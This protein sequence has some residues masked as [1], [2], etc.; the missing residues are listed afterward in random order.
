M[1][2]QL[3]NY[4]TYLINTQKSLTYYNNLA[5]FF[6]YLKEKKI[7]F[8]SMTKD[9]IAEYFTAKELTPASINLLIFSIKDFCKY[10]K[11]ES[12]AIFEMKQVKVPEKMRNYLT[13]DELEKAIK[14]YATYSTRGMSSTKCCALLKF[15]FFTGIRKSE[16]LNLKRAE[17]DL[18]NCAVKVYGIKDKQD[19]MV[20][21]PDSIIKDLV[22]YFNSEPEETNAF[23]INKMEIF[24]LMKKISKYLDRK[25][26]PHTLRH[27]FGNFMANVKEIS[28]PILQRLMGHSRIETTMIYTKADDKTAQEVYRKKVK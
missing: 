17:I 12:H 27:S 23:N 14:Y 18:T 11:I 28:L 22:N 16:L 1:N 26:T 20:Y 21:F 15:L 25:I 9:Q 6:I 13:Y 10:L 19:R 4:K 7:D 24:W 5:P 3:N 2:N 8:N